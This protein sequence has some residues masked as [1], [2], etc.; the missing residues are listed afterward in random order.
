MNL[1]MIFKRI[2]NSIKDH[3]IK[4]SFLLILSNIFFGDYLSFRRKIISQ[5]FKAVNGERILYGHF[6]KMRLPKTSFW[7]SI[8]HPSILL[9]LYER[10]V[11]DVIVDLCINK[12]KN[13]FINIGAADGYFAVGLL[14]NSFVDKSICYE[15][16]KEGRDSIKLNCELNHIDNSKIIIRGKACPGFH[17]DLPD[18]LTSAIILIDIEGFEFELLT[19]DA[20]RSIMDAIIIIELHPHMNLNGEAELLN[21]IKRAEKLYNVN[22]I[23]PGFRNPHEFSELNNFSDND[24]WLLCSEGRAVRMDWMVLSPLQM[25]AH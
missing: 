25:I 2:L 14:K 10:E 6:V 15:L 24:K 21:L 22:F 5:R 20:L 13:L 8:D 23:S 12:N 3:G 9:G 1:S 18:D 19:Q 16:T 7:N 11:L 17:I 4:N